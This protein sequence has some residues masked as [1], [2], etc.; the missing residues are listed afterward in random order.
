MVLYLY[1]IRIMALTMVTLC[2]SR[3]VA[4]VL[5]S[6]LLTLSSLASGF[7]LQLSSMNLW[8]FWIRWGSPL[9]WTLHS[10]RQLDFANISQLSGFECSRNPLTRQE[11]PGL[12]LKIPCGISNGVQALNYFG[13][14]LD[15]SL[16]F[17]IPL[18]P[19]LAVLAFWGFWALIR[20]LVMLCF[21]PSGRRLS[22]HKRMRF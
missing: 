10:L 5:T 1:T 15:R 7:V 19:V 22:R 6:F 17:N 2:P 13:Q 3:H 21:K 16:L 20:S 12:V 11:A 4:T 9:R 18:L 14:Y 8:T